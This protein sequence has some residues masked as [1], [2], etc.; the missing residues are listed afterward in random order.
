[1]A[2]VVWPSSVL[3][4]LSAIAS[5][6]HFD[7]P[8]AGR[9]LIARLWDVGQSLGNFPNRGRPAPRDTR[10]LTTVSPYLLRYR[11]RDDTVTILSIRHGARRPLD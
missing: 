1:M 5:S 8:D 10:V 7:D 6:E 4:Q 3:R 11:V 9:R 2:K